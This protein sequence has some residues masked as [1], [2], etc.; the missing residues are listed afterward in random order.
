MM[1]RSHGTGYGSP[2]RFTWV[3]P[4]SPAASS[5]GS[6]MTPGTRPRPRRTARGLR[7][8]RGGQEVR[9]EP[10]YNWPSP[11]FEQTDDH[12]VVNVSW[13]D[14]QAFIGWLG[15][16]GGEDLPAADGGGVGIRLPGGDEDALFLRRRTRGAGG[17][18]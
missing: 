13:N 10:R 2:S 3:S 17:G 11:G 15:K 9:A 6:W 4:R 18:G 12:P 8:E 1:T 5:A 14:A 7:L 16:E